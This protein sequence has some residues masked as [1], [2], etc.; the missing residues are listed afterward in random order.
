M[1]K[2]S[3][4]FLKECHKWHITM[5]TRINKNHLNYQNHQYHQNHQI[6]N[7]LRI[8]LLYFDRKTNQAISVITIQMRSRLTR[9]T[10]LNVQ[11]SL[12]SLSGGYWGDF[13]PLTHWVTEFWT[14]KACDLVILVYSFYIHLSAQSN[15]LESPIPPYARPCLRPSPNLA[16]AA[17]KPCTHSLYRAKR[18]S[19]ST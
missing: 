17:D 13:P 7:I 1:L 5:T 16:A 8:F 9:P 11:E 19:L 6:T 14:S 4:T 15:L 10:N 18:C 12:L 2:W 3:K